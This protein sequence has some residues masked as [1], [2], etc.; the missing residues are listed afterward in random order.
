VTEFYNK[1]DVSRWTP[2][3]E[4]YVTVKV[5]GVKNKLQKRYLQMTLAELYQL[6]KQE[7]PNL[8]VSKT[9]FSNLRPP[10][11]LLSKSMPHNTCYCKYHENIV[12]YLQALN[13][14]SS[15]VPVY[16]VDFPNSV[17]CDKPDSSCWF[18]EC[19]DCKDAAL[20]KRQYPLDDLLSEVDSE[21]ETD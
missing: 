17:V 5:D 12:L 10:N 11:V 19:N 9:V 6:F 15:T 7:Q 3:K 18:N 16:S 21:S 1:E 14:K 8:K 4:E 2:G 13:K 20:F